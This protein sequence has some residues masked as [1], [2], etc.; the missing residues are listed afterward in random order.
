MDAVVDDAVVT[1][2]VLSE[3]SYLGRRPARARMYVLVN[4]VV[5]G[6]ALPA[7]DACT[8]VEDNPV[9]ALADRLLS[10]GAIE[11]VVLGS[12]GRAGEQD[13]AVLR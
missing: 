7:G 3:R 6:D 10:S 13:F 5:P 4:K 8:P 2:T 1:E 12:V 9:L 11:G